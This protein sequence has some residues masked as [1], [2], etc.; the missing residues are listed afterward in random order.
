MS[1]SSMMLPPEQSNSTQAT[2]YSDAE[3]AMHRDRIVG[4]YPLDGI[5]NKK[6]VSMLH[7]EGF[8]VTERQLRRKLDSWDVQK[9]VRGDKMKVIAKKQHHRKAEGKKTT[10]RC[11]GKVV[12]TSDINR[13]QKRTAAKSNLL[14]GQRNEADSPMP[15]TPSDVSYSTIGSPMLATNQK[16]M[17]STLSTPLFFT[18]MHKPSQTRST[19]FEA[20]H[21]AASGGFDV[22]GVLDAAAQFEGQSPAPFTVP[23]SP[24]VTSDI[25]KSARNSFSGTVLDTPLMSGESRH[26]LSAISDIPNA[27]NSTVN[28]A[29]IEPWQSFTLVPEKDTEFEP[30]TV[31]FP[32]K[33]RYKQKE[34]DELTQR[35]NDMLARLGE[36]H[37][38]SLDTMSRLAGVYLEQSRFKTAGDLCQRIAKLTAAERLQRVVLAKA[39]KVMHPTDEAMLNIKLSIGRCLLTSERASNLAEAEQLFR[40]VIRNGGVIFEPDA[41]ILLCAME[42]LAYALFLRGSYKESIKILQ[43]VLESVKSSQSDRTRL[44]LWMGNIYTA[45]GE[46]DKSEAIITQVL[47]DREKILGHEHDSTLATQQSLGYNYILQGRDSEAEDIYRDLL[48]KSRK[49]LGQLHPAVLKAECQLASCLNNQ[50]RYVEAEMLAMSILSKT[51]QLSTPGFERS[52]CNAMSQAA[53]ACHGQGRS[54]EALALLESAVELSVREMGAE[55]TATKHYIYVHAEITQQIAKAQEFQ[56]NPAPDPS[57]SKHNPVWS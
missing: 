31:E 40:E 15:S 51:E 14:N 7:E 33:A 18:S 57:W 5:T 4:M 6:I 55:H 13:W 50:A 49:L 25:A 53:K 38:A 26:R 36:D 28:F 47:T 12:K 3:W 45:T 39:V 35:V 10:F 24:V 2:K 37:P 8:F 9:N 52:I 23:S 17:E 21:S 44:L 34:E 29:R 19:T 48:P 20:S 22:D 30:P 27:S 46:L 16:P 41:V 1:A 43:T 42:Y 56:F 32:Q 11:Q 54:V